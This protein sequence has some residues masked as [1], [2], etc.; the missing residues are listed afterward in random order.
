MSVKMNVESKFVTLGK[1]K[2]H[3]VTITISNFFAENNFQTYYCGRFGIKH[4]VSCSLIIK[5]N[6]DKERFMMQIDGAE[7]C[8]VK[9]NS[10]KFVFDLAFQQD[11]FLFKVDE[12]G[13]SISICYKADH[14]YLNEIYGKQCMEQYNK[15]RKR[16]FKSVKEVTKLRGKPMQ[17]GGCSPR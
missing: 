10:L 2:K 16:A 14:Q 5:I 1:I 4:Y 12:P 3:R 7:Y 8:R 6:C 11:A 13:Y 17:G 9:G 15:K